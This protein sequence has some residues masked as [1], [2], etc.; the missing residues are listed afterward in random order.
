MAEGFVESE[1]FTSREEAWGGKVGD[2]GNNRDIN[3]LP[4]VVGT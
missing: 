4:N 2:S 3:L 1:S